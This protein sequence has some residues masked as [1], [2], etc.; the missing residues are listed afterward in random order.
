MN[1]GSVADWVSGIGSLTAAIAALYLAR[2]SE[3][4]RLRGYCGLRV[5]LG[6]GMPQQDL[7]SISVTNVGTRATIVNNISMSVGRGRLRKKRHAIIT[8]VKD[9]YSPGIPYALPDGHVAHWGIPIDKE[10]TW[11]VDLCDG[12]V[13]NKDEIESIR[14]H[15]HTNHGEEL[16][17]VPEENFRKAVGDALEKLQVKAQENTGHASKENL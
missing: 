12:F 9:H 7:L 6:G 14:F 1:W 15:I 2:R 8:V 13:K 17:I 4:I 11:F 16:T 10:K 3:R 5:V